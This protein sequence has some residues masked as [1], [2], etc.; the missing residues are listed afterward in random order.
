[1]KKI[2]L[3]TLTI[4]SLNFCFAQGLKVGIKAGANMSDASGLSF[5]NGFKFG[6]Q[7]GIF[8]EVML[9]DKFG[10]QPE[11]IL[12]ESKLTRNATAFN[13]IYNGITVSTATNIKLQYLSLP[14]LLNYRPV[15]LISFLAGPQFGILMNQTE[16]INTNAQNAFKKGDLS[17]LAGLQLNLLKFRVYGRYAVGLS[18]I[19]DID[20]KDKWKSQN[21]QIGVGIA[22]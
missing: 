10:I 8:A 2:I 13:Q 4:L 15:S 9:S 17:V 19:N 11:A 1:M 18:N 21:L 14:V 22:L 20:N 5:Q 12:S 16:S 3:L 6:Y 7:G